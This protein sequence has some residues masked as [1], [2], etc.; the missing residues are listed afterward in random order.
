MTTDHPE[1]VN[2]AS[3]LFYFLR[4]RARKLHEER[5]IQPPSEESE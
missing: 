4:S 5:Q 3:S 2:D 1:R